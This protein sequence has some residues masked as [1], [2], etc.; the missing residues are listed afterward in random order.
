MR[1][2]IQFAS[3]SGGAIRTFAVTSCAQGE[4]KT[5][6]NI[7]LAIACAQTG[8]R[9]LLVDADMRRPAVDRFLGIP[10]EPGLAESIEQPGTWRTH[11]LPV[12]SRVACSHLPLTA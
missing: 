11:V 9:V 4:G 10:L 12:R 5:T 3:R 6:T 2:S 7:D 8:E 1:T